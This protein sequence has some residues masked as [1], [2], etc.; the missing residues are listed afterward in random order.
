MTV[1]IGPATL[2]DVSEIETIEESVFSDPWSAN[3][4]RALPGDPRVLFACARSGVGD[5]DSAGPG[6]GAAATGAGR[7]VLGYVV[8]IFA[9]DEGEIGNLAVAPAAQGQGIGG[10]LLDAVL[11]EAERRG[12]VVL[13]LE[14]RESNAAARQLYASRGFKEAGRRR[15]YYQRPVEDALLLR[16]TVGPRLK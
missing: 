5:G 11:A 9:A 12:C 15:G 6:P 13:Y 3:S 14:V 1:V 10:R 4:F 8:A 7:G 16:R 2:A